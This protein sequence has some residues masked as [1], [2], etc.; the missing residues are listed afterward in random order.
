MTALALLTLHRPS[1]SCS[2]RIC[3]SMTMTETTANTIAIN[4]TMTFCPRRRRRVG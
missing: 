3:G 2:G 4:G 1:S